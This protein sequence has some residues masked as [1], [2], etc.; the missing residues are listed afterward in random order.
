VLHVTARERNVEQSRLEFTAKRHQWWNGPDGWRQ[1]IPGNCQ[2]LLFSRTAAHIFVSPGDASA[3]ITQYVAWMERQFNACQTPR[4]MYLSIFNSF[5]VIRCLSQYISPKIAIFT[6]FV[7]PG[8]APGAI[9]L[10]VIWMEREFDTYKLPRW[11]YP[12]NYNRFWDRAIYWSKIVIFLYRPCIRRSRYGGSR[13]NIATP[14]GTEKL[15]WCGYQMVKKFR[16]YLCSFWR[17]SQTWRTD[18]HRVTAYTAPMHMHRAVKIATY[19]CI[20]VQSGSS[21]SVMF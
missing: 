14:F 5:P 21:T 6:S 20:A 19:W 16:R 7:S 9:T 10:N 12:S 2:K 11:M 17:S 3:I 1:G 8:D 4:S 13:R 15:E 18:G